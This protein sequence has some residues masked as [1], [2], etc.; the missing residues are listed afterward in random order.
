VFEAMREGEHT[1]AALATA[2]HLD[3]DTL[4]LLLRGLVVC[5]Y[6]RQRPGNR[7]ALSSLGRRSMIAGAPMEFV[8]FMRFN[9]R[10]WEYIEH[11]EDLVRTGRGV[12]F[13]ETM[14]DADSWRDYQRA[15]LERARFDAP[16]IASRVP[17][18]KGAESLLDIAGSHG[19]LGAA[20]CRRHP[21]M[22]SVV[23]DLPQALSHARALASAE[24][25]DDVV[26]HREGDLFSSDL[27]SNH[28]VVLLFNILHHFTEDQI[29]S[30]L[31]R[32]RAATAGGGTVA[33]WE[34]EAPKRGSRATA[35]DGVALF[36]R[37]TSTAGAYHGDQYAEWMRRTGF[38]RVMIVRPAMSPG[39]VLVTARR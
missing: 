5:D 19:L 25:I 11:L 36:F 13:H 20:I 33:V 37:L 28:D 14:T 4:E 32:V 15:M 12:D 34:I 24:R 26:T 9:Y 17:V 39:N 3:P 22:H 8:G 18:R 23:L 35:G 29:L 21:P 7:F 38:D 1:P 27:G 16:I 6:V 10:L 2:L 30:I 31:E